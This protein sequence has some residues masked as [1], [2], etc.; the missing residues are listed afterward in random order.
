M[1]SRDKS[2]IPTPVGYSSDSEKLPHAVVSTAD[3]ISYNNSILGKTLTLIDAIG[4]PVEQGK[5]LKSLI[6]QE[7]WSHYQ[8][9]WNWLNNQNAETQSIFPYNDLK[10][11]D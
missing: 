2:I 1:N 7:F 3:F 6:K 10:T 11:I 9:V 5:A 4:L 8:V